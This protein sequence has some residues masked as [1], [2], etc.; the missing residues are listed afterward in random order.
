MSLAILRLRT[1]PPEAQSGKYASVKKQFGGLKQVTRQ[2]ESEG[3]ASN[4]PENVDD[5]LFDTYGTK[6]GETTVDATKVKVEP[7]PSKEIFANCYLEEQSLSREGTQGN[8]LV[9]T[10]VYQEAYSD[11]REISKPVYGVDENGRKTT[12]RTYVIL[13]GS[14]YDPNIGGTVTTDVDDPTQVLVT[15]SAQEG[16]AVTIVERNFLEATDTL[17]QLGSDLITTSENGL[18]QV[19]Q[20]FFV[21]KGYNLTG[22]VGVTTGVGGNIAGLYLSFEGFADHNATT[23]I[24]VR[25]WSEAGLL[26]INP[27]QEGS[28]NLVQQ[29]VYTS[30]GTSPSAIHAISPLP[31]PAG[32][33]LIADAQ[34]FE[35]EVV[36]VN[37]YPRYTQQVIN[38]PAPDSS[39]VK[40]HSKE[41]F[42]TITD[43]GVMN[44][45]FTFN[46]GTNAGTAQNYPQAESKPKT[47]RKKGVVEVYLTDLA[48]ISESEVAYTEEDTE[49]AD[50]AFINYFY[51]DKSNSSNTSGSWRS[52]NNYLMKTG[53]PNPVVT[54]AFTLGNYRAEALTYW[55]GDT[56]FVTSGIY[57]V[58]LKEYE[59]APD[60]KQLYLKTIVT[61]P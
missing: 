5:Y 25:R 21:K 36:N 30:E 50:A 48:T 15:Q 44:I 28:F 56:S 57:R 52:F 14:S 27:I 61:F 53:L 58:L 60:G 8:T 39:S 43:P 32:G 9:L 31:K 49:W 7:P 18:K 59:K 40:I 23:A 38:I 12:K 26:A 34:F 33:T 22:E 45:G 35:P 46:A 11:L 42:F 41:D 55:N 20:R 29:Y 19:E 13:N 37:G 54:T 51:S 3:S 24:V 1:I 10:K 17:T 6:D 16:N 4:F 47:Y 2:W